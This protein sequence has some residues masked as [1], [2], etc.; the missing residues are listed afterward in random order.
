MTEQGSIS[1]VEIVMTT[2]SIMASTE[3]G[4]Y[5][6]APNQLR[7]QSYSSAV[8]SVLYLRT[9]LVTNPNRGSSLIGAVHR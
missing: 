6:S 7:E 1:Y 3:K 4:R 2:T 8:T 9:Y 5:H